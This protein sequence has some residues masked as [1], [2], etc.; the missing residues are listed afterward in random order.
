M[1]RLEPADS[2]LAV[3]ESGAALAY[4]RKAMTEAM[5]MTMPRTVSPERTLFA[6][7]AR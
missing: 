7:I 6:E 2:M 1:S 5:P 3:I 4:G